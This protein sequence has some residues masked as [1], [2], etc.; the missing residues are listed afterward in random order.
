MSWN[1]DFR[2]ALAL[3][4]IVNLLF[5]PQ[6]VHCQSHGSV[7]TQLDQAQLDS[8]ASHTVQ[9]IREASLQ[10][11]EPKVLVIDFFRSAQEIRRDSA[12]FLLIAFP[13]R[14]LLIQR[15]CTL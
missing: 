14:S 9:K 5:L 4:F 1:Y 2:F 10:G 13:N 15:D 11:K 7:L 8:L 3:A 12:H 6:T